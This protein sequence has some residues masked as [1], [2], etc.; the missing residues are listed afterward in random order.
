MRLARGRAAVSAGV[1]CI[2]LAAAG[3]SAAAN[4]RCRTFVVH[5]TP[6]HIVLHKCDRVRI[7]LHGGEQADP[8]YFWRVSHRPS[9]KIVKLIHGGFWHTSPPSQQPDPSEEPDQYWTYLARAKGRTSVT[10]GFYTASYPN[11]PPTERFKLSIRV[12]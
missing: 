7:Q 12:R 6:N 3:Q 5:E 10:L 8:P 11:N 2:A 1:A 4:K 9:R